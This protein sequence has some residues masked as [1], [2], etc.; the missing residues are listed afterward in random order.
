MRH[1]PET[2]IQ[3]DE[4]IVDIPQQQRYDEDF[5]LWEMREELKRL[6]EW[7]TQADLRLQFLERKGS[8]DTS[9]DGST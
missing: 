7:Q 1:I 3:T 2:G 6:R 5:D 8:H 4:D 9:T